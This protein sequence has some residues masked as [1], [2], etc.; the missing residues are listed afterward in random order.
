MTNYWALMANPTIYRIEDATRDLEIDRWRIGG[1][2]I[3][4]A[5]KVVIWKTYGKS[6]TRGIISLGEV[7]SMPET[8]DDSKN[9]Y[10]INREMAQEVLPRVYIRYMNTTILPLW[11]G[12]DCSVSELVGENR[13]KK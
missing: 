9:P 5:D 13:V 8:M 3:L 6:D 10:W 2:N 7:I 12:G 1:S 4:K 11:I